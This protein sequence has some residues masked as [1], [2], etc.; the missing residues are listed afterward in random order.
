MADSS[1]RASKE[2]VKMWVVD[3]GVGEEIYVTP[4]GDPDYRKN[5]S[6]IGVKEFRGDGAVITISPGKAY[7]AIRMDGE[8]ELLVGP[9]VEAKKE[10]TIQFVPADRTERQSRGGIEV[11][12]VDVVN[13]RVIEG[14]DS[15]KVKFGVTC[16]KRYE[17]H[18]R[19]IYESI[20]R[21]EPAGEAVRQGVE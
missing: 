18:R 8:K 15:S 3:R 14:K 9:E 2:A 19:E 4:V 21:E 5:K 12:V 1:W 11:T 7:R 16:S 13:G 17:P 6:V 20:Q 10:Y